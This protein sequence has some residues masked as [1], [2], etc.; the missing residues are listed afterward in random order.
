MLEAERQ[1][2]KIIGYRDLVNLALAVERDL[3]PQPI[4]EAAAVTLA[5]DNP[6]PDRRRKNHGARDILSSSGR[7]A[8]R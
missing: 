2:R 6:S 1:S 4:K 3:N 8:V 5:R 7:T